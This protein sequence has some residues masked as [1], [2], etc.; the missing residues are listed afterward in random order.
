MKAFER[1]YLRV[2]YGKFC[3]SF[4]MD[5]VKIGDSIYVDG[6]MTVIILKFSKRKE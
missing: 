4:L 3:F 6:A 5:P 2:Y 1:R